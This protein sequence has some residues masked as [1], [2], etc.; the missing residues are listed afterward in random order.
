M[1]QDSKKK[2]RAFA[3][4]DKKRTEES[5]GYPRWN[6]LKCE[7]IFRGNSRRNP[8]PSSKCWIKSFS[9]IQKKQRQNRPSR[10]KR[11]KNASTKNFLHARKFVRGGKQKTFGSESKR[12][13]VVTMFSR[14]VIK[15]LF[16]FF[17]SENRT[18]DTISFQRSVCNVLNHI[19]ITIRTEVRS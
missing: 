4:F 7:T 3:L 13:L 17:K 2:K 11:L 5:N 14:C 18:H 19:R 15:C 12:Y 16:P 8:N 9:R 6:H 1:M 10:E